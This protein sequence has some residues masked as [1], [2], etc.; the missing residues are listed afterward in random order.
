[1][2]NSLEEA[3]RNSGI[4][5]GWEKLEAKRPNALELGG[6]QVQAVEKREKAIKKEENATVLETQV[7]FWKSVLL[8]NVPS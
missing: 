3:I 1:V 6:A 7:C 4:R 5:G 8:T 2:F